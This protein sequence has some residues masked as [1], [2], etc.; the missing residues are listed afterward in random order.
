MGKATGWAS[1][2]IGFLLILPFLY[3]MSSP[4]YELKPFG[5]FL[6]FIAFLLIVYGLV[7]VV[8]TPEKPTK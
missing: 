1:I 6:T 4:L 8:K 3:A 5:W 2:V 7:T